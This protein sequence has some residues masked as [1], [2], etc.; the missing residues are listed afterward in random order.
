ML[1]DMAGRWGPPPCRLLRWAELNHPSQ[2]A[3]FQLAGAL[4]VPGVTVIENTVTDSSQ[5]VRECDGG[6][7]AAASERILTDSNQCVRE[8]ERGEAAAANE[9]KITDRSK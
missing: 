8:C 5:C 6:E 7:A 1:S 4:P 3:V 2:Q 9:R